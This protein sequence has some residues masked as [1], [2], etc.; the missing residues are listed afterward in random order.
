MVDP[1]IAFST[2]AEPDGTVR[3]TPTTADTG[4]RLPIQPQRARR[5]R[6]RDLG[7]PGAPA[8]A[9]RRTVPGD[10]ETSV[11]SDTASRS[12][13]IRTRRRCPGPHDD[14][15]AGRRA[16]RDARTDTRLRPRQAAGPAT[17]YTVTVSP[18]I[19]VGTTDQRLEQ[20]LTFRFETAALDAAHTPPP[21]SSRRTCSIVDGGSTD[22]RRVVLPGLRGR[23][24]P[25]PTADER[26]AR[27]LPVD[28]L[29]AAMD[30]YRA[31]RAYPRWTRLFAADLVPTGGLTRSCPSTLVSRRPRGPVDELPDRL[32]AGWY[33]IQL[34]PDPADPG[35]AAGDGH[36][37]LPRGLRYQDPALDERP[38]D[39]GSLSGAVVA[40]AGTDLGRTGADGTL[41]AT[42][43]RPSRPS[44]RAPARSVRRSRHGQGRRPLRIRPGKRSSDPTARTAASPG[45]DDGPS[46]G[47]PCSPTARSIDRPT[48]ST[49]GA[50]SVTAIREGPDEVTSR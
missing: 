37:E 40:T 39:Q 38:R 21:S 10:T 11:P 8:V 3:I 42:R 19:A 17:L 16:L 48:P 27:D 33:L 29:D 35:D 41:L 9:D 44:R 43:H 45:L 34:L 1:P 18:G 24:Q 36:R 13:S 23:G 7:L 28:G 25:A 14:P 26:S 15:A 46:T 6:G 4:R 12:S 31:I 50:S 22:R 49:R 30:T 32:P 2:T 20:G 5:P 47:T